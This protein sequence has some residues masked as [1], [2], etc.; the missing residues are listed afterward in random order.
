MSIPGFPNFFLTLGPYT[1]IA[2]S[3][4]KTVEAAANHI[5]RCIRE[6]HKKS[7]DCVEVRRQANDRYFGM[8]QRR[9]KNTVFLGANCARSNSYYFDAHGDA[10]MLRPMTSWEA[11]WRSR[12]FPLNDYSYTALPPEADDGLAEGARDSGRKR[13]SPS[14]RT[15]AAQAV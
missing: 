2:T 13:A 1:F 15:A 10:P 12:H 7:A 11:L 8:I 3:Y 4:F 5:V 14:G 9:Q 6:A